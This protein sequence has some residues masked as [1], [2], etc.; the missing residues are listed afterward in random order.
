MHASLAFLL[1]DARG[2][3]RG[4]EREG[5]LKRAGET[6]QGHREEEE[7]EEEEERHR[8]GSNEKRRNEKRMRE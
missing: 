8:N 3:E 5:E 4:R 6:E 7:E 1:V 2:E